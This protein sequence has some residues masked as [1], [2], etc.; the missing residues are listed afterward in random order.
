M[1][2][3][4]VVESSSWTCCKCARSFKGTVPYTVTAKSKLREETRWLT[5]C[6]P[7]VNELLYPERVPR[8]NRFGLAWEAL[9]AGLFA[10]N[11]REREK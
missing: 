4:Q 6:S 8:K 3:I 11:P 2:E 7:C 5:A 1:I 10:P 9:T